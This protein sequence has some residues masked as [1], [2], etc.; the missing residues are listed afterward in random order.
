[1]KSCVLPIALA[2]L[3]ATHAQGVI[4]TYTSNADYFI[5]DG[6]AFFPQSLQV[7]GLSDPIAEIRVIFSGL[8]HEHP[9]DIDAL[10]VGPGGQ[11]VMLMSDTGEAASFPEITNLQLEFRDGAPFLP[12]TI[13][14]TSGTYA[15]TNYVGIEEIPEMDQATPNPPPLGPYGTTFSLFS[16]LN[17]NGT[18]TLYIQDDRDDDPGVLSRWSLVVTT[19]PEPGNSGLLLWGVTAFAR[20]PR[21]SRRFV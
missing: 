11:N 16:G 17:P 21:T 6:A 9:S 20:R 2:V 8:T 13:T 12:Q 14:L 5:Q 10:L 15:P 1:M 7:S 4:V 18:W 19:I 3:T